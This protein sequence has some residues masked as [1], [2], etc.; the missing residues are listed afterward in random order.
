MG[1]GAKCIKKGIIA[2]MF[3][4]CGCALSTDVVFKNAVD[5]LNQG[6]TDK[7]IAECESLL[8]QGIPITYKNQADTGNR[9]I[10]VLL[11]VA[12]FWNKDSHSAMRIIEETLKNNPDDSRALG[13]QGL[14]QIFNKD[15][16][17][18][19][20]CLLKSKQID[21]R[22]DNCV[23]LGLL[24]LMEKDLEK[25]KTYFNESLFISPNDFFS[26]NCIVVIE[27]LK[28]NRES[29]IQEFKQTIFAMNIMD[30]LAFMR[31]EKKFDSRTDLLYSS[32]NSI[33]AG[34]IEKAITLLQEYLTKRPND[35]GNFLFGVANILKGGDTMSSILFFEKEKKDDSFLAL[36]SAWW[37]ASLYAYNENLNELF[38][39]TR[40]VLTK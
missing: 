38:E 8:K 39:N 3:F 18:A 25:A 29:A 32:L 33:F 31:Y 24:S 19:K 1:F 20:R 13:V 22:S 4:L 15:F 11:A 26:R 17:N 35:C 21:T 12:Y 9:S 37:L 27:C 16:T 36:P 6:K 23:W 7:T 5:H 10:G 40:Y 28:G 2:L 34:D 14:I 30:A